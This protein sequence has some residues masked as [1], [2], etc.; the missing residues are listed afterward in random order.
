MSKRQ[1]KL[2]RRRLEQKAFLDERKARQLA[3]FEHNF[4]AGLAFYESIKDKLSE[5][6]VADIESQIA[7]NKAI[8]D[9]MKKELGIDAVG[10]EG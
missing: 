2:E 4:E 10:S 7:E 3:L 5:A 8:I 6:E 1:E 9:Q